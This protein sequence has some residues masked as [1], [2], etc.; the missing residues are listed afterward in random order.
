MINNDYEAIGSNS[1]SNFI[2]WAA[3]RIEKEFLE[4][5]KVARESGGIDFMPSAKNIQGRKVVIKEKLHI[6]KSIEEM[7]DKGYT[8][9]Y[10][11]EQMGIHP[12]TFARWKTLLKEKGLL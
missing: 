12:C 3:D 8:V 11:C 9:K 10:G 7:R 1:I 2:S 6:I 5:E 4:N